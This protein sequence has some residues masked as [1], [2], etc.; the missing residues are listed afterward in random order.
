MVPMDKEFF[1]VYSGRAGGAP[2]RPGRRVARAGEVMDRVLDHPKI[3][4][5]LLH[6]RVFRRWPQIVGPGMLDKCRPVKIKRHTLYLEVKNSSWAHQ[7]I[8]LQE[9]IISRVNRLAGVALISAIHCRVARGGRLGRTSDKSSLRNRR[10]ESRELFAADEIAAW[11]GP[12]RARVKDP[13]LAELLCR[14][15]RHCEARKRYLSPARRRGKGTLR[16]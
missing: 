4:E 6:D 1:A 16:S 14:M 10:P 12:I 9:E 8:Y 11:E 15:R 5:R 3:R 7:L 2:L 13:E